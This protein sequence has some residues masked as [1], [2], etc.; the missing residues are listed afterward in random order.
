MSR[1]AWRIIYL[2]ILNSEVLNENLDG[3][4]SNVDLGGSSIYSSKNIKK[5]ED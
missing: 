4:S 3:I 5:L 1:R 2:I